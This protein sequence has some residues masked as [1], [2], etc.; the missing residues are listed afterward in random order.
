MRGAPGVGWTRGLL[1]STTNPQTITSS[2]RG[3]VLSS[4][5]LLTLYSLQGRKVQLGEAQAK[6]VE[7]FL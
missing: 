4:L 1:Y 5:L 6:A 7:I 2:W 3:P